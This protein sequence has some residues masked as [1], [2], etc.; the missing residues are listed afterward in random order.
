MNPM[1][2]LQMIRE[3]QNPQQL[4]INLLQTQAN[5]PIAANLLNMAQHN[6]GAGIEQVARNV[7][8]QQGVNFDEAFNSF[9]Q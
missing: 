9:K 4:V 6:D 2:F 1:Q 7:C 8:Q 5:N 3:G